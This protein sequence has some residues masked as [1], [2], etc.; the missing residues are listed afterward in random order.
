M[1]K[2]P[3]TAL[4]GL[5][6]RMREPLRKQLEVAAKKR[7]VSLN[8]ELVSRLERSFQID[9]FEEVVEAQRAEIKRWAE[10]REASNKGFVES[11]MSWGQVK[12][13]VEFMSREG[14]NWAEAKRLVQLMW[15]RSAKPTTLPSASSV[16]TWSRTNERQH[17]ETRKK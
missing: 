14:M 12:Q 16:E 17:H 4:V 6:V 10:I 13:L 8:A 2:R 9:S 15:E 7:G 11:G 1:V 3:Q 5:R